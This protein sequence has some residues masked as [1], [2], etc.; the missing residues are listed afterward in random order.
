MR[1]LLGSTFP[2]HSLLLRARF[3]Q[4]DTILLLSINITVSVSVSVSVSFSAPR[5]IPFLRPIPPVEITTTMTI[6]MNH[7]TPR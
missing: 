2:T 4:Q 6:T 7:R 1:S 3:P 5:A